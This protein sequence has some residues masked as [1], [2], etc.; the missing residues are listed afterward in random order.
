MKLPKK[1][2]E[3]SDLLLSCCCPTFKIALVLLNILSLVP[4]NAE[5]KSNIGSKHDNSDYIYIRVAFH[6]NNVWMSCL[7]I[8]IVLSF[9]LV[10]SFFSINMRSLL[11][12]LS[13]LTDESIKLASLRGIVPFFKIQTE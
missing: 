4:A 7:V 5:F 3:S 9:C 11:I 1:R 10:K 12:V 2:C 6:L 8:Q 13:R